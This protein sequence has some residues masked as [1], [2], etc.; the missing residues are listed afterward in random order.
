MLT[1][2]IS[3][4][5]VHAPYTVWMDGSDLLFKTRHNIIYAV[6]FDPEESTQNAYWFNLYN[7][8]GKNSP[9]DKKLRD[10]VISIIVEFFRANPG[11]LLY[12]CDTAD[13]RQ[14]MRARL[15]LRWFNSSDLHNQ[16]VIRV[17]KLMDENIANYLVMI[18][19]RSNPDLE[20][21]LQSI[22]AEIEMFKSG[23]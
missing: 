7:R 13:N 8:S 18:V 11:I 3:R 16:F 17:A 19:Q 20:V 22:D 5:N 2:N 14:A 6:V 23:K 1:L 21:I 10:T 4:L 9:N 12:M 15:F